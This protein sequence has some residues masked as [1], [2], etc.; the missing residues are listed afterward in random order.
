VERYPGPRTAVN[1]AQRRAELA[2]PLARA[3]E[4][5]DP[6]P[7]PVPL[8]LAEPDSRPQEPLAERAER[9]EA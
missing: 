1:R 5:P 9:R 3:R 8:A 4:E 6:L 7:A 2:E